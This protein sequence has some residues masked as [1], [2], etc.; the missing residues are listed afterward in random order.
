MITIR[1]AV[2]ADLTAITEIYNE[3][4]VDSHVS[5][6]LDA[7]TL[8]QRREWWS[9][10]GGD[11][12]WQVWVAAEGPNN[13]DPVLGAAWSSR[14]RPKA[15]YDRAVETTV[16]LAPSAVGRGVGKTLYG[17]LLD[18]IDTRDVHRAYAVIALP[19][20]ESIALHRK[21]GFTELSVQSE[22]GFKLGKYWSTVLME[23]KNPNH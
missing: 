15:A 12:P 2:E 6:D 9:H 20:D 1:P 21:L 19:N 7:W 23:R 17:R 4:I 10:Y 14:Y 16:V 11:T 18:D 8:D 22:V 13:S 3:Y 5:F